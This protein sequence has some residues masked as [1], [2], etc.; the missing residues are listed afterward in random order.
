MSSIYRCRCAFHMAAG[1]LSGL[2]TLSTLSTLA[3]LGALDQTTVAL[4]VV[5]APSVS[6]R[7]TNIYACATTINTSRQQYRRVESTLF[8]L[9]C[10]AAMFVAVLVAMFVAVSFPFQVA[11]LQFVLLQSNLFCCSVIF[12]AKREHSENCRLGKCSFVH[13]ECS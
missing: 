12:S 6:V 11:S 1:R 5:I 13:R 4:A 8:L 7:Y 2:S 10:S 9:E 3:G